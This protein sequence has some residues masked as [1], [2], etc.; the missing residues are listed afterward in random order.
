LDHVENRRSWGR[1]YSPSG[2]KRH[3]EPEQVIHSIVPFLQGSEL[4]QIAKLLLL[5]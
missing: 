1:N 4:G 5:V 3:S 2:G